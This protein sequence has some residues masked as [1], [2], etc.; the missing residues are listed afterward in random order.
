MVLTVE[1][2]AALEK[3]QKLEAELEVLQQK[4]KELTEELS[5]RTGENT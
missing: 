4:N 2:E 3:I 5:K 1:N